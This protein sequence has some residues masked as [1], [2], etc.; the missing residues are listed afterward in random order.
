MKHERLILIG[1]LVGALAVAIPLAAQA[2]SGDILQGTSQPPHVRANLPATANSS[3]TGIFPQKMRAAYGFNLGHNT[4]AG[5]TIAIVDAFDDPNIEADF[6]VFNTTF[7]LPA[8][9][10]ANGCFKKIYGSGTKPPSDT[11]GWSDEMAIDVQW[12]HAIAPSAKIILVE[13][14]SN[15]NADLYLAVDVAV[16]NGASV[17]SMSWGGGVTS[18]GDGGHG[19]QYPAASPYVVAVGG[20]S[21]TINN[22]TG[23]WVS[24]TAW[25]ESGGGASRYEAEPTY[26]SAVIKALALAP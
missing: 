13:A 1:K 14:N 7:H 23:A 19:A 25:N 8:C 16:A 17:V 15:S 26:Q 18:S 11:S 24:E 4:G 2:P 10:T 3:P 12:A 6:G 5:Q 22:S 21:L 20:T 9:T